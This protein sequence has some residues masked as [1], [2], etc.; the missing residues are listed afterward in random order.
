M[1]MMGFRASTQWV[2]HHVGL[3][4]QNENEE[5]CRLWL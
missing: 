1:T 2:L 5:L 4:L 3:H